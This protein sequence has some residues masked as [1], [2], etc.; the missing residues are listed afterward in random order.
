MVIVFDAQAAVTPDGKP[1]AV[2][3][4]VAPVVAWVTGVR[5]V[6]W[7]TEGVAEGPVTVLAIVI[8]LQTGIEGVPVFISTQL[9]VVL[10]TSSPVA[11][12]TI[13]LRCDVV[14]RGGNS[15]RLPL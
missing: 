10:K 2:P 6:F 8:Q 14:R 4:P 7:Q 13:A 11:G 5:A 12:L 3:I 9:R 1:V 15:P